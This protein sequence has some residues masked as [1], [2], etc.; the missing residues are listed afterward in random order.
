MNLET[1]LQ[2]L[3]ICVHTLACTDQEFRL[4]IH[5]QTG[6][7]KKLSVCSSRMQTEP[8]LGLERH[9]SNKK[10][11]TFLF[12]S[13]SKLSA[14]SWTKTPRYHVRQKFAARGCFYNIS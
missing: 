8:A 12:L 7:R 1:K 5:L 3:H 10:K 4:Y 9:T 14:S 6:E 13:I 11:K 2:H